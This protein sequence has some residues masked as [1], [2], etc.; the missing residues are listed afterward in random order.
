M[1]SGEDFF[2]LFSDFRREGEKRDADVVVVKLRVE[3]SDQKN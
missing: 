3:Q 1:M 2:I